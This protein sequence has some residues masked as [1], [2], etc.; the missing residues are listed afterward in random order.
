MSVLNSVKA[1]KVQGEDVEVRE[2]RALDMLAFFKLV[3]AQAGKFFNAKGD[4]VFN[5]EKLSDLITGSEELVQFLVLKSTGRD[6]EWLGKV[7][8]GELLDLLDAAIELNLTEDLLKKAGRLGDRLKG[9]FG[10]KTSKT[11][12]PPPLTS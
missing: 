6:A 10:P 4:V 3:A 8:P 11:D 7:S 2:L 9:I 1:V 5:L 12:S